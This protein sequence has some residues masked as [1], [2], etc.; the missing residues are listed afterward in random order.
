MRVA[1][2]R[3]WFENRETGRITVAQFPNAPLVGAAAA[4]VVRRLAPEGSTLED[5]S[6]IAFVVLLLVWAADEVVRGVNPWRRLLGSVVIA[7]QLARL[8]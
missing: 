8:L 1:S 7:W 6:G 5:L 4:W 3:W 2:P